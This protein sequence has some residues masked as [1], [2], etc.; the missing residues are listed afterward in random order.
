M[1][2]TRFLEA[3]VGMR[4]HVYCI[5]SV[6]N[7]RIK[8]VL[9]VLCVCSINITVKKGSLVAVVGTVGCGKSSLLAACLGDMNILHGHV[10]RK[11]RHDSRKERDVSRKV[12]HVSR[13]V[14]NVS[15]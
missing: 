8:C 1:A 4:F 14:R 9:F 10:S 5:Y 2:K 3:I 7:V 15:R 6:C 12:R 11:V 13:K